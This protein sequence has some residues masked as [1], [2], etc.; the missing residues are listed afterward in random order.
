MNEIEFIAYNNVH[1]SNY[2]YNVPYGLSGYLLLFFFS[3]VEFLSDRGIIRVSSNSAVLYTPKSRI[4]YRAAGEECRSD[5]IRFRS[6]YSFIEQ[7]PIR[8]TPF[9]VADPEY[10]HQLVKLMTWE[11]SFSSTDNGAN[12]SHLMRVLFSKLREGSPHEMSCLHNRE[13]LDLRKRIYNNPHLPW[14]INKIAD[15]LHLSASHVQTLYREQFGSSCMDD[16]IQGRL[17]RAQD[18][19]EYTDYSIREISEQCGYNNVEHFCRQF[20]QYNNCTP[21]QYRRKIY[22]VKEKIPSR[23]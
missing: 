19:L 1:S 23:P 20:R 2:V 3:P 6:D 14:S 9:S 13:L 18:F 16:V 21:G 15:E 11:S 10:C 22:Q 8:N 4:C 7:F 5:W 12:I 17:R